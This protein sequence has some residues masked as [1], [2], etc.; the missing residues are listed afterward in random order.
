[1][2]FLSF[3]KNAHSCFAFSLILPIFITPF[4]RPHTSFI[5]SLLGVI[6]RGFILCKQLLFHLRYIYRQAYSRLIFTCFFF[7]FLF[8]CQCSLSILGQVSFLILITISFLRIGIVFDTYSHVFRL[9]ISIGFATPYIYTISDGLF[10]CRIAE[11]ALP[12]VP[13]LSLSY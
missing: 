10:R 12:C 11:Q 13:S 2:R 3:R 6:F 1:M 7:G 4:C 9:S 8:Y 5:L